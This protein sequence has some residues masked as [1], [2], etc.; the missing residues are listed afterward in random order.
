M[1]NCIIAK[2]KVYFVSGTRAPVTDF[3][4]GIAIC[5]IGIEFHQNEMLERMTEFRG[6]DSGCPACQVIADSHVKQINF[7]I[8][9][10]I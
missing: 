1:A 9:K 8:I 7:I 6:S 10:Y 5:L 4:L 2:D 3:Q